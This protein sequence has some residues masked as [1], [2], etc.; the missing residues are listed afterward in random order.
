MKNKGLFAAL[1]I[2]CSLGMALIPFGQAKAQQAPQTVIVGTQPD[3]PPF[4][5]ADGNGRLTGYDLEILR[6]IFENLPEYKLDFLPSSWDGITIGLES[7]KTQIIADNMTWNEERAARYHLSSPYYNVL[8]HLVVKK[9]RTDIN[10]LEDLKGKT[11]ELVVGTTPALAIE[12]WNEENGG[13]I[14]IQYTKATNYTDPLQDVANGRVDA[15]VENLANFN[16]V[17]RERNLD[18]QTVGEPILKLPIIYVFRRDE[19][20]L[21]LKD[22]INAGL[23]RLKSDGTLK[24]L[25]LEWTGS[26]AGVPE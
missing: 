24:A 7:N 26:E 16:H 10:S 15:Y 8:V 22:K 20:G 25:A 23:D 1:L 19:L 11:L 18:I 9:G 6:I 4:C 2:F 21:T 13:E 14:R 17:V 5:F 12:K 3:F